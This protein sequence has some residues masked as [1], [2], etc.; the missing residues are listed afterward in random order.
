MY[1]QRFQVV[2]IFIKKSLTCAQVVVCSRQFFS[3]LFSFI[4]CYIIA[5]FPFAINATT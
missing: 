5:V 3:V 2:T 4:S 1:A